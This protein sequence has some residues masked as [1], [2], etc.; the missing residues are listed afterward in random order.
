MRPQYPPS[1]PSSHSRQIA[2]PLDDA[3]LTN[4]VTV[5]PRYVAR[6]VSPVLIMGP[7]HGRKL[8]AEFRR[9]TVARAALMAG[10]IA[11]AFAKRGEQIVE[12]FAVGQRTVAARIAFGNPAA[13]A[14][15]AVLAD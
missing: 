2:F 8:A 15:L 4:A 9:A 3:S 11:V 6:T 5:R 14:V 13:Q 1:M 7:V 10:A 12:F